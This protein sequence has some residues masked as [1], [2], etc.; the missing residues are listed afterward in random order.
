M[1]LDVTGNSGNYFDVYITSSMEALSTE[2]V[3]RL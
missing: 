1:V 2:K 3:C